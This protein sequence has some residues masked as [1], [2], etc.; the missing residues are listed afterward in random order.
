MDE[1]L[2][3]ES[4]ILRHSKT[5]VAIVAVE[6]LTEQTN[7]E[8]KTFENNINSFL[9]DK[10]TLN[11]Y[12]NQLNNKWLLLFKSSLDKWKAYLLGIRPCRKALNKKIIQRQYFLFCIKQTLKLLEATLK[13][14]LIGVVS[15]FDDDNELDS[16]GFSKIN[17]SDKEKK[18]LVLS[19]EEEMKE[20]FNQLFATVI[21]NHVQSDVFK[22]E[23]NKKIEYN[24]LKSKHYIDLLRLQKCRNTF[25]SLTSSLNQLLNSNPDNTQLPWYL[26]STNKPK[27]ENKYVELLNGIYKEIQ[28]SLKVDELLGE[29]LITIEEKIELFLTLYR[30]H[31]VYLRFNDYISRNL[32]G[33]VTLDELRGF[34]EFIKVLQ[35]HV[36]NES[37]KRRRSDSTVC[38]S[39]SNIRFSV[40]LG[41]SIAYEMQN[42]IHYMRYIDYYNNLSIRLNKILSFYSN[43]NIAS[44]SYNDLK[45]LIGEI[46]L[47]K[48]KIE[49]YV[50]SKDWKTKKEFDEIIIDIDSSLSA[51]SKKFLEKKKMTCSNINKS[52]G[53]LKQNHK[54]NCLQDI[55]EKRNKYKSLLDEYKSFEFMAESVDY[56]SCHNIYKPSIEKEDLNSLFNIA[57]KISNTSNLIIKAQDGANDDLDIFRPE[58]WT[59]LISKKKFLAKLIAVNNK[60]NLLSKDIS[61]INS[62]CE[63]LEKFNKKTSEEVIRISK[64]IVDYN[65]INSVVLDDKAKEAYDEICRQVKSNLSS[66]PNDTKARYLISLSICKHLQYLYS[67]PKF[68]EAILQS[69]LSNN[70][71]DHQVIPLS[72]SVETSD[73]NYD[74]PNLHSQSEITNNTIAQQTLPPSSG[75]HSDNDSYS[76]GCFSAFWQ[77]IICILTSLCCCSSSTVRTRTN[78][79]GC[80]DEGGLVVSANRHT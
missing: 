52:L 40:E 34:D 55:I 73:N 59:D 5:G 51:I 79:V 28:K 63:Y 24:E 9:N 53:K 12:C 25:A 38:S 67:I 72:D 54:K 74:L 23:F 19:S 44:I 69:S 16:N 14:N 71:E 11:K 33:P 49:G 2:D 47:V 6:S 17:I 29:H 43:L 76:C 61:Q 65:L 48:E 4:F 66:N 42:N 36:Y 31:D 18:H 41:V 3:L 22:I 64:L 39:G 32:S 35:D 68:K 27:H 13:D 56:L 10:R 21:N 78:S 1:K 57:N 77:F 70:G 26:I 60:F 80:N 30:D 75:Y 50:K 45:S 20:F 8:F 58:K 37:T 62:S 7:N 15:N 46:D